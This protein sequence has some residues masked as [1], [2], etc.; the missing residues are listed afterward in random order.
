MQRM[1]TVG[2]DGSDDAQGALRWAANIAGALGDEVQP[3]VTWHLPISIVGSAGRRP[4]DVD[5]AG[6]EATAEVIAEHCVEGLD[7]DEHV[8]HA[9]VLEGHPAP[10]LLDLSAPGRPIVV[11]R[12]GVSDFRHRLLGSTSSDLAVHAPGPVVVV[13]AGSEPT[14]P[15]RIVVGFDG[16]DHAEAALRWAIDIAPPG[17]TVEAVAAIDIVPWLQPEVVT[18]RNAD[19]V[20]LER[21]RLEQA[22]DAVDPDGTVERTF[23][24]HGPHQAL[25]DAFDRADLIVV[26]P[27]GVG[28]ITRFV[29]G[30]ITSWLLHEVPCPIAVVPTP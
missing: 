18:Q 13:P 22:L 23:V 15:Q 27:R 30:T 25:S 21:S 20:E 19:D 4:I 11:G 12:R 3:I 8:R 1:W 7:G 14:A 6:L 28:A 10:V 16:S 24:L 17:S 29:L 9:L 26:G 5:R 2:V